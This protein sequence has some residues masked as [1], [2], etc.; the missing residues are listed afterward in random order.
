MRKLLE[1]AAEAAIQYLEKVGERK[2]SPAAEAVNNL[3]LFRESLPE[4]TEEP[5]TVLKILNDH[6]SPATMAMA[7]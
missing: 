1:S 4:T 2:V 7:G 6:G 5:E 3:D